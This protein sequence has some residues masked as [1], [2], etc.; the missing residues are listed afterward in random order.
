MVDVPFVR[1][2]AN[3]A[4]QTGAEIATEARCREATEWASSLGLNPVRQLQVSHFVGLP[5]QCSV[6]IL[7]IGDDTFHWNFNSQTDNSRFTTGEF[8]MICEKVY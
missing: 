1:M 3:T 7:G 8:V 4:C 5:F 2:P 6:Q